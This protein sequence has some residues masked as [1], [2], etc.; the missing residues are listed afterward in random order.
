[1][2]RIKLMLKLVVILLVAFLVGYFIYT[3]GQVKV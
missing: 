3:A 2:N 1:M